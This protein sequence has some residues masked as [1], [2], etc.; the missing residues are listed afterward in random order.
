MK[1]HLL[2][3]RNKKPLF[4]VQSMNDARKMHETKISGRSRK[5]FRVKSHSKSKRGSKSAK[6]IRSTSSRH[7]KD[8]GSKKVKLVKKKKITHRKTLVRSKSPYSLSQ[9]MGKVKKSKMR[10]P[11]QQDI[12]PFLSRVM[13][14]YPSCRSRSTLKYVQ[15]F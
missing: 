6:R 2:D 7:N 10:L 15:Y 14:P 12:E 5:L 4:Y 11:L 1:S 3:S 8:S 13:S 9:Q